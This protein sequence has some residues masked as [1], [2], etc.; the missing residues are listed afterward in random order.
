VIHRDLK[1]SNI[2][3]RRDESVRVL[4]FGIAASLK[5]AHSRATG[6]LIALSPPYASPEQIRG[7]KPSIAMDIYSLGCV[8]YEML[9]GHPPFTH[10][11]VLKQH[12]EKPP[13]PM[14]GQPSLSRRLGRR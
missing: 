2:M 7:E 9:T 3:I 12:L 14:P 5:E 13:A 10:G 11:D 6:G 8:F 4:D 1:P